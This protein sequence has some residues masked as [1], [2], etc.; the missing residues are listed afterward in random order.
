[1]VVLAT[2]STFRAVGLTPDCGVQNGCIST[3]FRVR[4]QENGGRR[5]QVDDLIYAL[6][7]THKLTHFIYVIH[8]IKGV[9][10]GQ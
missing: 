2:A 6:K 1:M 8:L 9:R 7:K 10:P 4:Q 3:L 5:F